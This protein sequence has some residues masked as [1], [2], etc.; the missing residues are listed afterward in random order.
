[1]HNAIDDGQQANKGPSLSIAL[2]AGL[3]AVVLRVYFGTHAHVM[4]P[5]FEA[6]N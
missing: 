1:M 6:N 3:S 4:Q 2:L 5:I